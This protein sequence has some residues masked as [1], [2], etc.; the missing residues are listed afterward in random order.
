MKFTKEQEKEFEEMIIRNENETI[1]ICEKCGTRLK[2]MKEVRV[3]CREN[4]HYSYK[5]PKHNGVLMLV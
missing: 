1:F 4:E 2:G 3:H 5:S